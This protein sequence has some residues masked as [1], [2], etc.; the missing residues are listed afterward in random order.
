MTQSY[1]RQLWQMVAG[2]SEGKLLGLVGIVNTI[3]AQAERGVRY[4][5][6]ILA[7]LSV[8][9]FILNLAPIPALDGGPTALFGHGDGPGQTG[10]RALRGDRPRHRFHPALWVALTGDPAGAL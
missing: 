9:L 5:F 8:G 3:S 10:R 7:W 6:N 1:G 2:P 4:L